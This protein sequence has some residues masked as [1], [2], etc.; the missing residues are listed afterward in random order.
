MTPSESSRKD[1]PSLSLKG[2]GSLKSPARAT[3]AIRLGPL[4]IGGG[5]PIVV[6]TMTNTSS[7]DVEATLKQIGDCKARG[8]EVVRLAVPDERAAHIFKEIASQS[9]LPLVADIH[10]DYRLALIVLKGGAAGLRLNPGNIGGADKIV[11]VAEAAGKCGAAIR[12]GVNGG[13][14]DKKIKSLYGHGPEAMVQSALEQVRIIEQTGFRDIKV[15][16]KSSEVNLTVAAVNLF[17]NLSDLPQHLGITEAG[18][19]KS[20][21]VRS[22]VALGIL[23]SQGLG[24]TI[25]V[26]LTA[27]PTEEVDCAWEI[28]RSLDLRRRGPRF[29]SCPTCGRCQ[30]DLEKLS[31]EVKER[32]SDLQAPLTVAVMGCVVNGPGEASMADVALAG[33]RGKGRIFVKGR[34]V[35]TYPSEQLASQLEKEARGLAALWTGDD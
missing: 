20:G 33:G 7:T 24:D 5:Q 21:A 23:L 6:Q 35:G 1:R 34:P 28:L 18:D 22:A 9:P 19:A 16:L 26:S 30:I 11:K 17:S 29:I 31:K 13:S 14:L 12:V 25:R 2:E 10:F 8:A 27:P 3:R 4:T 32:L 15:S